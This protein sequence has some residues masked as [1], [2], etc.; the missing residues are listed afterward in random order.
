MAILV[1]APVMAGVVYSM[2]GAL[3]MVGPGANGFSLRH[4]QVVL[5]DNVTWRGLLWTLWIA[6]AST[7]LATILA[8]AAAAVF[9]AERGVDRFALSLIHI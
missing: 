2:F 3:G 9:R 8:M 4:I 1:A 7:L 6:L 5:A